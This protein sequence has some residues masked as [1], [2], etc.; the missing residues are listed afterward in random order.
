VVPVSL[1]NKKVAEQFTP[2]GMHV[3]LLFAN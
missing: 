2:A 3:G 1:K